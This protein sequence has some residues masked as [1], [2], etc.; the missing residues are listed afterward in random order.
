MNLDCGTEP[1]LIEQSAQEEFQEKRKKEKLAYLSCVNADGSEKYPM[2]VIGRSKN[3][4][5]FEK[6]DG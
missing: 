4:R 1:H 5:C 2:F 3:P 6:F